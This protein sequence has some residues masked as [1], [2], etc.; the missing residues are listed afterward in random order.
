MPLPGDKGLTCQCLQ[1]VDLGFAKSRGQVDLG[2]SAE[3][4]LDYEKLGGV[5]TIDSMILHPSAPFI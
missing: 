1:I 3:K 2:G 4:V 5:L